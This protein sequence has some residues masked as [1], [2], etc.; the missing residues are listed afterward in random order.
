MWDVVT[1]AE[2]DERDGMEAFVLRLA[3]STG[4]AELISLYGAQF[5]SESG[6]AAMQAE[7]MSNV[8]HGARQMSVPPCARHCNKMHG[9]N[10]GAWTDGLMD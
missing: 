4:R 1:H 8:I 9:Q 10:V 3:S 2:A 6:G 7:N 5:E